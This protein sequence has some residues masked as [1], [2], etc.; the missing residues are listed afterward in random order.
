MIAHH[1]GRIDVG[2]MYLAPHE[3]YDC[4]YWWQEEKEEPLDLPSLRAPKK[5]SSFVEDGPEVHFMEMVSPL[6]ED[7]IGAYIH[8]DGVMLSIRP[9]LGGRSTC[10][11]YLQGGELCLS[12]V[13]SLDA[14]IRFL[15][16]P[17]E[18]L[19]EQYTHF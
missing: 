6:E 12:S 9:L 3:K 18:A 14:A 2:R 16:L 8:H 10:M 19:L 5:P 11:T 4:W 13:F 7:S 17:E 15:G 1:R